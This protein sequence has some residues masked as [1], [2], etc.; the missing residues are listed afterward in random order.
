MIMV[1]GQTISDHV[2]YSVLL[3][4]NNEL[5]PGSD[6]NLRDHFCEYNCQ[7]TLFAYGLVADIYFGASFCL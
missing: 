2:L 1:V 6:M 5:L 4:R 3:N 7:Q